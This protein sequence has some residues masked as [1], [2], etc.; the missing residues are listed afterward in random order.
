MTR[1]S[2]G[3]FVEVD[4][5]YSLLSEKLS[6]AVYACVYFSELCLKVIALI[7]TKIKEHK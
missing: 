4:F 2:F 3:K 6:H 5:G 7:T 1:D